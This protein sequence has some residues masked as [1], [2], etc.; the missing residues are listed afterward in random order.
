MARPG[1]PVG[2]RVRKPRAVEDQ[3]ALIP[4]RE[5]ASLEGAFI[6]FDARSE[7]QPGHS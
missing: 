1:V 2:G 6:S 5:R 4:E 3:S 7:G